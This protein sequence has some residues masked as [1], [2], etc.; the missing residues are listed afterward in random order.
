MSFLNNVDI[1]EYKNIF[2]NYEKI[3]IDIYKKILKYIR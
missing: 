3:A 1:K 2:A